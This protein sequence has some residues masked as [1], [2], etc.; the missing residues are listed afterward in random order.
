VPY[1]DDEAYATRLVAY[2]IDTH[3]TRLIDQHIA[4]PKGD[5]VL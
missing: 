4:G 1:L 2:D 5:D 3:K